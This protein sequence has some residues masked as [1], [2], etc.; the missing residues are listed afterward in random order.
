[1]KNWVWLLS[2]FGF[3]LGGFAAVNLASIYDGPLSA[4]TAGLVAGFIIGLGQWLTKRDTLSLKWPYFTAL[5]LGIG[6]LFGSVVLEG[7]SDPVSLT[8]FGTISGLVVG[9]AQ[10][11]DFANRREA[12][13]WFVTTFLLWS[14]SWAITATVIV[15]PERG[16]VVFGMS[17]AIVYTVLSGILLRWIVKGRKG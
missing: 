5:G 17:G 8:L 12:S 10:A 3:P 16:Y 14:V 1:M 7:R 6:G 9:T 13:L 4:A 11:F 2:V 15:D